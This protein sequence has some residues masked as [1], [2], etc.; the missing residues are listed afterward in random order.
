MA[1]ALNHFH[2]ICFFCSRQMLP[3]CLRK[4]KNNGSPV[5][6]RQKS[7]YKNDVNR[8]K[9]VKVLNVKGSKGKNVVKTI[10]PCAKK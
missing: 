10:Q 9:Y 1:L 5:G 4:N 6:K 7:E 8:E 3:I 2:L